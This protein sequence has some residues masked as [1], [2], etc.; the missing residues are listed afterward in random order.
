MKKKTA[1][2]LVAF[3]FPILMVIFYIKLNE[4]TELH[5]ETIRNGRF[6]E[7]YYYYQGTNGQRIKHGLYLA[8]RDTPEKG[9]VIV[10][11]GS[12]INGKKVGN[13]THWDYIGITTYSFYVNDRLIQEDIYSPWK[14]KVSAL[15]YKDG[16]PYQGTY[17]VCYIGLQGIKDCQIETYDNGNLIKTELCNLKGEKITD[18]SE[19]DISLLPSQS[20]I[21][22]DKDKD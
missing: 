22:S 20:G 4:T 2:F 14:K 5:E 7:K 10:I 6:E 19:W 1:Y 12:Y 13:W 9:R 8:T 17:W 21:I 3:S 16:K 18:I 15:E 11:Q